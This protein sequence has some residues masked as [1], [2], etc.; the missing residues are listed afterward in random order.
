MEEVLKRCH[1]AFGGKATLLYD[2]FLPASRKEMCKS[3]VKNTGGSWD[4]YNAQD[5]FGWESDKIVAVTTGGGHTREMIT[6]AR[7]HLAIILMQGEGER[8][9]IYTK[10]QKYFAEAS[11]RGL[12]E[13]Q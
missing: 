6:R 1:E 11:N 2:G 10:Y 9:K 13:L 12:I 4:C 3:Y 7:T 5:F 8:K